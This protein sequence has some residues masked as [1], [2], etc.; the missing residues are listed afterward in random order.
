MDASKYLF[1]LKN[2]FKR[3]K[4]VYF[5]ILVF[6]VY[7]INFRVVTSADNY[8]SYYIPLSILN[9][10]NLYLNEYFD[11]FMEYKPNI[12]GKKPYYLSYTRGY[13]IAMGTFINGLFALPI[14]FFASIFSSIYFGHWAIPYLAKLTATILCTLSTLFIFLSAKRLSNEKSAFLIAGIFAFASN[15]WA[16]A[17]QDLWSHTSSIF[18]ISL[19]VYLLIRALKDEKYVQYLGFS[20]SGAVLSRSSNILIAAIIFFYIVFHYE[21]QVKNFLLYTLPFASLFFAYNLFYQ[22]GVKNFFLLLLFVILL[23]FILFGFLLSLKFILRRTSQKTAFIFFF[24]FIFLFFAF[25]MNFEI[26][27]LSFLK[28]IISDDLLGDIGY[29]FYMKTVWSYS[30]I[31]G[32]FGL[33]FNPSRGLLIYS[34]VFIFSFASLYFIFKKKNKFNVF[35]S[36]MFLCVVSIVLFYS[37][38]LH[39]YGGWSFGYRVILDVIPFLSIL[40]IPILKI[41][42]KNICLKTL[43]L[44]FVFISLFIQ[45]IGVFSY[46]NSWNAGGT[47]GCN[48]DVCKER[49]WSLKDSQLLYYLKNPRINYCYPK[50]DPFHVMCK[51]RFIALL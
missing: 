44:I 35:L 25:F 33:L 39:W 49:L 17:S 5:L 16:V 30:L 26:K 12:V 22:L 7:N 51:K 29:L 8:P 23:D 34:P 1:S 4:L 40:L 10:G 14:F 2:H 19:S 36:F 31:K 47:K 27:D 42:N 13:Y 32:L 37:K 43:F 28:S 50:T 21:K 45:L 9:E 41:I 38:Y 48:I 6:I 18:F 11:D 24:A 15:M 20:L 3:K 46:D